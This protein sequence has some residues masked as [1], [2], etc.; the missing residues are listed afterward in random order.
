MCASSVS[1]KTLINRGGDVVKSGFISLDLS[2]SRGTVKNMHCSYLLLK[3]FFPIILYVFFLN[4]HH[5]LPGSLH[6]SDHFCTSISVNISCNTKGCM[7][8][9]IRVACKTLALSLLPVSSQARLPKQLDWTP[10]G[11]M[12][13][14]T[15]LVN[16]R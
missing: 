13:A 6:L 7:H 15:V 10:R 12:A 11:L 14:F 8:V 9:Y 2:R 4:N 16:Y 3:P 1:K 5:I